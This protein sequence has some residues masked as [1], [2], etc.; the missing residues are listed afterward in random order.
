[1]RHCG[2]LG[3]VHGRGSRCAGVAGVQP[4]AAADVRLAYHRGGTRSSPRGAVPQEVR[5]D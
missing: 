2:S 3:G 5:G 1:M 4:H